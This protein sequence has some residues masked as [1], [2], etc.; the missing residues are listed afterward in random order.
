MSGEDEQKSGQKEEV[1][2]PQLARLQSKRI[3]HL[4]LPGC[5]KMFAKNFSLGCAIKTV[6]NAIS[7]FANPKK[8]RRF[9]RPPFGRTRLEMLRSLIDWRMGMF[10]GGLSTWKVI[11][12]LLRKL[13]AL[14]FRKRPLAG[15]TFVMIR[16]I[17]NYDTEHQKRRFDWERLAKSLS[18]ILAGGLAGLS[19]L[20]LDPRTT[21]I[22]SLYSFVRAWEFIFILLAF[23]HLLPMWMLKVGQHI[24]VAL[25][26]VSA[27]QILYA[28]V[29][30]TWES[31]LLPS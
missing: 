20:W 5:L 31:A 11:S 14:T 17:F 10:V 29:L 6:I 21:K 1:V 25:M 23:R 4:T 24:D 13:I 16:A 18:D 3:G 30:G 2:N 28:Y 27:S 12:M 7:F 22:I 26:M 19:I 9:W 15:T 8:R